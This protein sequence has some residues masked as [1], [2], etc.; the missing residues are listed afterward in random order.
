[1]I[2]ND[3]DLEQLPVDGSAPRSLV[4]NS[5]NE[6][7]PSW[8]A[9][10]DQLIYSTDRSGAREIW[11]RNLKGGIDRAA[12]TAKDFP[13]DSTVGMADPVFSPDGGR[14]AF[15]RYAVNEPATIWIASAAG[16]A[17][18]RLTKEHIHSPTWSPD[19]NRVA[20]LMYQNGPWRPAIVGVGADMSAHVIPGA[21]TCHTAPDWSPAG[22]WLAC[23]TDN[24]IALLTQDGG[25][26]RMLPDIH[27][28][29]LAFSRDGRSLFVVGRD[30]GR[31]FLRSVD[32]AAGTV[33]EIAD[34]GP[35]LAISGGRQFDT[36][37][38]V[39]PDGKSLATSV[40][41]SKSEL[42]LLEGYPV[43]GPWWHLWRFLPGFG[44]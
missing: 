1:V 41:M 6:L 27:C 8:S 34:Y 37:L 10:G 20:G 2:Q 22:E 19:G 39:A 28:S 18:V 43:P 29:A 32:V 4:P 14:F 35:E 40:V 31:S 13:P 30:R 33:R 36:R 24:G 15:V 9:Q 21:P 44:R 26:S 11:I 3:Y 25:A 17:P 16:G 5:R 12:V 42:W 23:G 7:S 38:S